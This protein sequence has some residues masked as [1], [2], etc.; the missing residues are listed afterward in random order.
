MTKESQERQ[1]TGSDS[2]SGKLNSA[3]N[4]EEV[5]YSEIYGPSFGYGNIG[6]G[7]LGYGSPL[8]ETARSLQQTGTRHGVNSG[9]VTAQS[10]DGLAAPANG[11]EPQLNPDSKNH[12]ATDS[13]G[14]SEGNNPHSS[15]LIAT[16]V[17]PGQSYTIEVPKDLNIKD[18]GN[19]FKIQVQ[20]LVQRFKL[21]EGYAIAF[22]KKMR[23]NNSS[24]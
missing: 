9:G 18:H 7:D 14:T 19:I 12:L 3:S 15:N 23:Y 6:Y 2:F 20:T 13:K 1:K 10:G 21:E 11:S 24:V 5:N 16:Y 22:L 17:L 4:K 8:Q